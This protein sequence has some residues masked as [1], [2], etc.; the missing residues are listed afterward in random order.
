MGEYA[1]ALDVRLDYI[2]FGGLFWGG[3]AIIGLMIIL[4]EFKYF[5]GRE[6]HREASDE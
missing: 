3:S 1:Y 2:K 5:T 4:L 6:A